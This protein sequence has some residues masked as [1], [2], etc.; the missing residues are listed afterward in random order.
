MANLSDFKVGDVLLTYGSD[1]GCHKC[2]CKTKVINIDKR[3]I[4]TEGDGCNILATW[5]NMQYFNDYFLYS[6][7]Q[8]KTMQEQCNNEYNEWLEAC[9]KQSERAH[10]YYIEWTE[11]LKKIINE[12]GYFDGTHTIFE[13]SEG[14]SFFR[15]K[16]YDILHI[17]EHL[18]CFGMSQDKDT[19]SISID[20]L[21]APTQMKIKNE[22]EKVAA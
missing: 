14:H 7:E 1:M 19:M 17:N 4:V 20:D 12:K 2:V 18:E 11:R 6:E 15:W 3:G 22:L 10:Q 16:K 8:E 13:L 9:R 21:P 5:Q